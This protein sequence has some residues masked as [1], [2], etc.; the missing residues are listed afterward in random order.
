MIT[1]AQKAI[2]AILINADVTDEETVTA[3]CG[4]EAL[5]NSRLLTYQSASVKDNIPLPTNHF[6]WKAACSTNIK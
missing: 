4:A 1:S 5:M 6:Y 3:F 2:T